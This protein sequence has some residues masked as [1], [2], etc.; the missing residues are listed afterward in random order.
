[1]VPIAP[2]RSRMRCSNNGSSRR[3]RSERARVL[4]EGDDVL[5]GRFTRSPLQLRKPEAKALRAGVLAV[6]LAWPQAA[7]I[8]TYDPIVPESLPRVGH[9]SSPSRPGAD[10]HPSASANA[11]ATCSTLG[12]TTSTTFRRAAWPALTV[13]AARGTSRVDATSRI[14]AWLAAPSTGG[15][16][17]RILM[18]SP[19]GPVTSVRDARGWTWTRMRTPSGVRL[20]GFNCAGAGREWRP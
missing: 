10:S 13:T 5:L 8:T 6:C 20:I 4:A 1:M 11:R 19:W 7:Q 16:A 15:A 17:R 14:K 9:E 2:S 18:T 12:P 3:S